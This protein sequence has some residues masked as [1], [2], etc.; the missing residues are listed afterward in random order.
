LC[1]ENW[2]ARKVCHQ[3]LIPLNIVEWHPEDAD[4]S[5]WQW[6]RLI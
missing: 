1:S 3:C 2:K 5:I 4:R 6:R